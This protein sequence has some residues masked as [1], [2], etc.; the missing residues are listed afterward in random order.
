M[1]EEGFYAHPH[2]EHIV[3]HKAKAGFAQYVARSTA[4][5]SI[6][7]GFLVLPVAHADSTIVIMRH[8]EKPALGLG[9]LSCKGLNRSLALAPVLLAN[10][11]KPVAIYA[12]NPSIKKTDLGVAYPYLRPLATIEPLAIRVGMPVNID[13]GMTEVSQLSNALLEK[14]EGTQFV[15]WEHHLA[16]KLAKQLLQTLDGKASEVPDWGDSDFDSIYVIRVKDKLATFT[17]EHQGLNGQSDN[18]SQ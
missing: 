18:C 16:V 1:F 12:T 5:L 10:Y 14:S 6:C 4:I 17:L 15:A 13:W 8:G 3:E 11:G 7:L 2:H 9:Q